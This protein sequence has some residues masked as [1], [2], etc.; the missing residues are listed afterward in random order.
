MIVFVYFVIKLFDVA[1]LKRNF[2]K[3][4]FY[5]CQKNLDGFRYI[6][7]N[8]YRPGAN[9]VG[10]SIFQPRKSVVVSM[11]S[12]S[13]ASQASSWAALKT[14]FGQFYSHIYYDIDNDQCGIFRGREEEEFLNY[15]A[16]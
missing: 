8:Y 13:S 14:G 7:V 2:A 9:R 5:D 3:L 4:I 10:F 11:S 15:T 12:S 1:G 16:Y 6:A